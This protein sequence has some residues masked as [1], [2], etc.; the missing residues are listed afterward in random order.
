[1]LR[2]TALVAIVSL[3]FLAGL[4]AAPG[5]ILAAL[6]DTSLVARALLANVILVPILAIVLVRAFALSPPIAIGIMLMALSPGIPFLIVSAGA[7]KGG[8]DAFALSLSFLLPAISVITLPLWVKILA[9]AMG[10]L[11]LPVG[12]SV[13]TILLAQVVPLFAGLL[14]GRRSERL[15]AA[16]V[17]PVSIVA[18]V[19]LVVLVAMIAIPGAK[20]LA[21]VFGTRANVAILSLEVLSLATG[22]YLGGPR[23]ETRR[24]LALAT[25][26]RNVGLAATL[27]ATFFAGTDVMVTIVAFLIIQVVVAVLAGA[28]FSRRTAIPI[29]PAVTPA[30]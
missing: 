18:G 20:A 28:Y 23:P 12:R 3:M 11:D 26:L 4:R 2:D 30:H 8:S 15:R 16:L 19:A 1:M 5:S 29:P 13:V 22:W 21:T 7:K 14:I 6:R 17:R 25:S 27:A 10:G 24:T 9:P